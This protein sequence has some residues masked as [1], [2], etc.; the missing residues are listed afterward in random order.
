MVLGDATFPAVSTEPV[1]TME[2]I[3][4]HERRDVGICD[5]LSAFLSADKDKGVKMV[6][7]G[8]LAEMMVKIAPHI[9]RQHVIYEK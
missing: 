9:Y 2:I 5:I 6:L 4:A 1:L 8:S 7:H 3:N